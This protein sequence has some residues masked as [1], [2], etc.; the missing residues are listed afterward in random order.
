MTLLGFRVPVRG[1]RVNVV[2]AEDEETNARKRLPHLTASTVQRSK[3]ST[4]K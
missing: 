1:T 3:I 2:A 4:A